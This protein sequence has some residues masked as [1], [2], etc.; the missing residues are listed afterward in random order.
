MPRSTR[1]D[2]ELVA[3]S[4]HLHYEIG[5]LFGT[6]NALAGG[7][8]AQGLCLNAFIESFTLHAR[9][10]LSFLYS[11][12]P[13][14]DDVIGE[15][16]V[17]DWATRRPTETSSL[18][19]VHRRVG[20]EVAHLTYARLSV[21]EEA[22]RWQFLQLAKDIGAVISVFLSLVPDEKVGPLLQQDKTNLATEG[23]GQQV[24]ALQYR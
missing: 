1:S 18:Q 13:R 22:K 2:S 6:A 3:A 24:N 15:D 20:K 19:V 23:A 12:K 7:S 4:D 21:T 17:S 16:Y 10:L 5:M 8:C 11:D 14:E 9:N